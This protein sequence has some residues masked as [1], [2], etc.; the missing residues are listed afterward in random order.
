MSRLAFSSYTLASIHSPTENARSTI[1]VLRLNFC[2]RDG[3]RCGPQAINTRE[4]HR[5]RPRFRGA[6]SSISCMHSLTLS[7]KSVPGLLPGP[8][9][10]FV[11]HRITALGRRF[12]SIAFAILQTR[13]TGDSTRLAVL[14]AI[15]PISIARLHGL[16][17]FHLRPIDLVVFEGSLRGLLPRESS[18]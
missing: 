8:S 7:T 14:K 1:D 15:R 17:R 5:R 3:N 12:R 6:C 13:F 4:C 9:S 10:P 18:S 2:V 16:L 11:G